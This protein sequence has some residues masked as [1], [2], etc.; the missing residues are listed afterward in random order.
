[1]TQQK[2]KT[3]DKTVSG[4]A[5]KLEKKVDGKL[6][7]DTV[8]PLARW[9]MVSEAAYYRAQ[10]RGF[11]GGNPINDW[12]DAEKEIDA[13]YTVDYSKVMVSLDPSEVA[14]QFA[15]VFGG[16]LQQPD[17]NIKDVLEG[18]RK[19][20]EAFTGANRLLFDNTQSIMI[21]QMQMLRDAMNKAV[22][23]SA[24]TVANAKSPK[25]ITDQQARLIQ[26][27]LEKSLDGMREFTESITKTNAQAFE[28]TNQR[29]AES[30]AE[31]KQLVEKL[32]GSGEA[33]PRTD[34]A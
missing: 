31:L 27:G 22:S 13:K 7:K 19:N 14:E 24:Q 3:K 10:E 2:D 4:E 25:E 15:K 26:M 1:M 29:M 18:Q 12:M 28:I 9:K 16:V 20:I 8:S 23:S 6:E 30:I 32:K 21:H 11:I 5:S 34:K 17:F 33:S